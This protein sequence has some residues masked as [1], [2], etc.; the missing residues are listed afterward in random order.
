MSQLATT[1][2]RFSHVTQQQRIAFN[3]TLSSL[4]ATPGVKTDVFEVL[5]QKPSST[6]S[7]PQSEHTPRNG[8]NGG[9]YSAT[10]HPEFD[11]NTFRK[12]KQRMDKWRQQEVHDDEDKKVLVGQ[13]FLVDRE[14]W[15]GNQFI[16]FDRQQ[17]GKLN[18][19]SSAQSDSA[20]DMKYRT[21][22]K[23]SF[24]PDFVDPT[25]NRSLVWFVNTEEN[26]EAKEYTGP[27]VRLFSRKPLNRAE[28]FRVDGTQ[29]EDNVRVVP[30]GVATP[31]NSHRSSRP[32]SVSPSKPSQSSSGYTTNEPI[33]II[34]DRNSNTPTRS[35]RGSPPPPYSS[36]TNLRAS[37]SRIFSSSTVHIGGD[38]RDKSSTYVSS[39][40]RRS[41][42]HSPTRKSGFQDVMN[43]VRA[44]NSFRQY[45]GSSAFHN[46]HASMVV[47]PKPTHPP[48]F[49]STMKVRPHRPAWR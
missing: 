24:K 43:A 13:N 44:P 11:G 10:R 41:N 25:D 17:R 19:N 39:L 42:G 12:P 5:Y 6:R 40:N 21:F 49:V 48:I 38:D 2:H 32:S 47:G 15:N 26:E 1:V 16:K 37:P 36:Q 14:K 30:V 9:K 20:E 29:T 23:R 27:P 46:S 28:T 8:T 3:L 35:G 7:S 22:S 4:P 31:Y 18:R 33:K 45:N 34:I